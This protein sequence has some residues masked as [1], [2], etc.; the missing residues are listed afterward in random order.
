LGR[1][2]GRILRRNRYVG[3]GIEAGKA[4]VTH[5]AKVAHS[6]WLQVTGFVFCV[7]A[8]VGGSAA[9]RE[10]HR[11]GGHNPKFIA[12]AVFSAMFAYFGITAFLKA[13]R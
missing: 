3:A 6:L 9:W 4:T 8:L 2:S 1:V 7:F 13:R 12:A 10:F 5:T 11:F